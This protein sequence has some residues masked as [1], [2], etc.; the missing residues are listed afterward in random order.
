M[1]WAI[2]LMQRHDVSI[3]YRIRNAYNIPSHFHRQL[4]APSDSLNRSPDPMSS[5]C[6]VKIDKLFGYLRIFRNWASSKTYFNT[7]C[8]AVTTHSRPI[9][10]PPHNCF[11]PNT[12][13][14]ITD[15]CHGN[16]FFDAILPFIMRLSVNGAA[17]AF[18]GNTNSD[19]CK[20]T[21]LTRSI[22]L[23]CLCKPECFRYHFSRLGRR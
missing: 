10:D 1:V 6:Y 20:R 21:K 8:A 17:L 23:H 22:L 11:S 18:E 16:W 7:Q 14:P 5:C 3:H 13:V 12:F 4:M 2:W 19:N 15:T 9:N